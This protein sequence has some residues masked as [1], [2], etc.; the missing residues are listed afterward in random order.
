MQSNKRFSSSTRHISK[1]HQVT[2]AITG[3]GCQRVDAP[4]SVEGTFLALRLCMLSVGVQGTFDALE[5][6][7]GARDFATCLSS[8]Y[9]IPLCVAQFPWLPIS[10]Y[11]LQMRPVEGGRATIAEEALPSI[12]WISRRLGSKT[13]SAYVGPLKSLSSICSCR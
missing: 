13:T 12:Y 10:I 7:R 8:I 1:C 9:K 4:I 5:Q 2:L 6:K 11:V 3:Q